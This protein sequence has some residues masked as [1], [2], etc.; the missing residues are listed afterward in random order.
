MVLECYGELLI[1]RLATVQG[2]LTPARGARGARGSR[3][4]RWLFGVSLGMCSARLIL[5]AESS[6]VPHTGRVCCCTG[7]GGAQSVRPSPVLRSS[8]PLMV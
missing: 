4:G 2:G 1:Q 3:G 8:P 7:V 6:T 5:N